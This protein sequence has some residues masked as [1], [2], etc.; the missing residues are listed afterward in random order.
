MPTNKTTISNPFHFLSCPILHTPSSHIHIHI[1]TPNSK[2]TYIHT[3]IH[4]HIYTYTHT[5]IHTYT[6]TYTHTY[7]HI[8]IQRPTLRHSLTR[9][10]VTR[11]YRAPEVILS[12]P[13]SGAV[14][15]WSVGC[16]FGELL[17]MQQENVRDPAMRGKSTST[18]K[19]LRHFKTLN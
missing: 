2:Y 19:I 12:L 8:H 13:Y 11:W 15:V 14:D 5:Y 10:V 18:S 1:H 9:H 7:T 6:Y 16:I 3:Y 4:T 17:G